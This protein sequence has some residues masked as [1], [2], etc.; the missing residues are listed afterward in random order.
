MTEPPPKNDKQQIRL[1]ALLRILEKKR[2]EKKLA[3]ALLNGL[4]KLTDEAVDAVDRFI[5][6]FEAAL[7]TKV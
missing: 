4:M 7:E 6:E 3:E 5:E 1:Q 2:E